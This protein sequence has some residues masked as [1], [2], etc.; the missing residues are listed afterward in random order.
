[1]KNMLK[2]SKVFVILAIVFTNPVANAAKGGK[3]RKLS[4]SEFKIPKVFCDD[5][6][7]IDKKAEGCEDNEYYVKAAEFCLEK[8]DSE[9][10]RVI[11]FH[12]PAG[13][14]PKEYTD[15]ESLK[16]VSVEGFGY[17]ITLNQKVLKELNSYKSRIRLPEDADDEEVS[18]GDTERYAD[19]VPC[20]GEAKDDLDGTMEDVT[21]DINLFSRLQAH[22]PSLSEIERPAAHTETPT[23]PRDHQ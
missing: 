4:S 13:V 16:G 7:A 5:V 22:A 23:E 2:I 17:L 20:Y 11:A 15:N 9:A 10:D 8:L 6:E 3:T 18:A 12:T 1:M 19:D 14:E 21:E